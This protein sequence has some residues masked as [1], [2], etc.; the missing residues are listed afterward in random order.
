MKKYFCLLLFCIATVC[1][2]ARTWTLEQCLQ[3][4][5]ENNI[6]LQKAGLA[7]QS[8][9]EDRRQSSAQLLPSLSFSTSQNATYRPWMES[10]LATVANGQVE[11][12]VRNTFYNGSYQLGVNW[13]VWN[14]NRN[15]NQVKLN[16]VAEEAAAMDSITGARNIEEQIA[17]LFVQIL[18]TKEAID[19]NRATLMAAML[20][21]D[22]GR[23]MVE[24]GS[25]SRAD[26]S[27]LTAQRAQDEYNVVAAESQVR[28]FTRQLKALLQITDEEEFDVVPVETTDAMALQTI[29]ALQTVYDTAKENRPELKRAML[30]VRSAEIQHRIATALRMPTVSLNAAVSTN[31]SS[32]SKKA[33]EEQM[34]TNVNAGAGVTVS[35][36]IFDQRQTR[37]ARNKAD[38][39]RERALLEIRDKETSLY[40]TIE[41]YWIQ[42]YNNQSQYKAAKISSASAQESY[43]LLSEQFA[44][45]L[46]NIVEL[47]EGKSR[48]LSAQQN[49]LQSKYM[50]ILNI[51]MLEFYKK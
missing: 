38:L 30:D 1:S 16:E 28:N 39:Q 8:A 23:Q 44:V 49:E 12:S 34:K 18:Y 27:Q 43:D 29:P 19:V 6:T 32:S 5:M 7:R 24:V 26:L 13:T 50:T 21:E 51:K 42:A 15:R 14:G 25:M 47:Q 9:E 46:K 22:R 45:G 35:V 41:N 10:G 33:W 20:N 4:A 37:T 2:D 11:S 36:P 3:Y 31:T 17:Q 48:L 40:S